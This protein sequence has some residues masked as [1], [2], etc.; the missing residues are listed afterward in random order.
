MHEIAAHIVEIDTTRCSG[1]GRCYALAPEVFASD[2]QGFGVVAVA[3]V[4]GDLLDAAE[5]GANA[6]PERAITVRPAAPSAAG[7]QEG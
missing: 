2:D 5:R 4:T 1:H 6:C 7:V 3:D